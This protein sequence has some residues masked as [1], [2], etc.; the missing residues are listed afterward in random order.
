[1]EPDL[2]HQLDEVNANLIAIRMQGRKRTALVRG[3]LSGMGS[4]IGVAI[5]LTIIGWVL[6]TAGVIPAFKRQA[7]A[8]RQT[9]EDV[10]RAR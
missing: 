8:W 7:D 1:M 6:N 10:K 9:L 5:M 4:V 2:R 3:I